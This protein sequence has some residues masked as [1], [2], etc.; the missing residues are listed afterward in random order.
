VS[1]WRGRTERQFEARW[2]AAY[3]TVR[4]RMACRSQGNL[5][6]PPEKV[7]EVSDA[8]RA[9]TGPEQT[10]EHTSRFVTDLSS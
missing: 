2:E 5:V 3:Y 7:A 1:G 10:L 4:A 9:E 6:V 8:P